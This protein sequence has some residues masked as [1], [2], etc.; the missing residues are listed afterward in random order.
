MA[1]LENRDKK[2]GLNKCTRA[3]QFLTLGPTGIVRFR[4]V[5]NGELSEN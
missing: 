5:I 1:G 3:G 4:F 2:S